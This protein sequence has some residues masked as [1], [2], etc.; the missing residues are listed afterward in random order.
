[1]AQTEEKLKRKTSAK[2]APSKSSQV[3]AQRVDKTAEW[4]EAGNRLRRAVFA[5][6]D[7]KS[8]AVVGAILAGDA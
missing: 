4:E 3:P 5:V 1:M 6:Y 8:D 2:K 7:A